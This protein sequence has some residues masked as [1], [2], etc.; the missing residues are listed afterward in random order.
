MCI[1]KSSKL[2]ERPK[3]LFTTTQF[4]KTDVNVAKAEKRIAMVYGQILSIK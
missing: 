2:L 4:E 1:R 3:A